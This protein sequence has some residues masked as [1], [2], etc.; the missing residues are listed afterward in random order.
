MTFTNKTNKL[1][2]SGV[3]FL[4]IVLRLVFINYN[5]PS[6]NWDEVSH[7][8][9]AYSILKTGRDEWGRFFPIT[10]FR[11]YG[12]YPLPLNLYLTIP[13]ISLF[14]INELS[15]RFPHAI[16]GVLTVIAS[17]YLAVGV[18][19]NKKL[20]LITAFLVAIHPWYLFTS[21]FVNQSNLSIF[22][23]TASMAL[24]F[25]REKNKYF[26]PVSFFLLVLTLF[27]YHTTRIFSPLLL[28]AL[29]I[30]YRKEFVRYFKK[31]SRGSYISFIILLIF[32]LPLPLII[33]NPETRARSSEVFLI[34]DG[35][36]GKIIEE[37]NTSNLPPTVTRLL[38]NRPVY[39]VKE[40]ANNYLGYFSPQ[41]LFISGGT[42]YQFSIPG[43]GMLYLVSLP[44]FYLGLLY[45]AKCGWLGKKDYKLLLVWLIL[46]PIPASITKEYFAVLR[47]SPI[48]PLPE[49]FTSLGLFTFSNWFVKK[50]NTKYLAE[51]GIITVFITASLV[52][53]YNYQKEYYGGYKDDYSRVWQY[54]YKQI[55]H[56]AKENYGKY[57]KIIVTKKYGEPH[58][59]F[60]FYWPWDPDEYRNDP[61]LIRFNKSNW[62]WVDGFDKFY[63]V[64][65]WDIPTEE[66]QPFVL[67]S[68]EIV[69]CVDIKCLL[70]TS[71]SNV[72]KKWEILETVN[73]LDGATAFEI[74]EN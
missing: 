55:V 4:A 24:F 70:I 3:I 69:S 56:Y 61:N 19:K 15:I 71:P 22:F 8:Y 23:L 39:F 40:F 57:G 18:T 35:V 50:V 13:F 72:P 21:R 43:R 27:S 16:L 31:K 17:Y 53:L 67:E 12:D 30:I 34:D 33:S 47:S 68:G 26:L 25:N 62:Y 38:H 14:G 51:F 37:R 48:L 49:L 59:F 46:A 20:A 36:V 28:L 60:L 44:F 63:F 41:Y 66:W 32:F 29:L 10:N 64:N 54:G 11:A 58:E 6:L 45:V 1:L 74:Y 73:F 5:P 42:Q 9:N 52:A 2:L 65:D 7:G